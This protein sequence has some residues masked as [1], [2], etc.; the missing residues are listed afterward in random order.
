MG[1]CQFLVDEVTYTYQHIW[2]ALLSEYRVGI[3]LQWRTRKPTF[4]K[5][6][7]DALT[8]SRLREVLGFAEWLPFKARIEETAHQHG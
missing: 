1:A 5:I 3:Y 7:A 4:T 6:G 8:S 2:Y